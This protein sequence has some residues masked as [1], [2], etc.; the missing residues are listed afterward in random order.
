MLC[1]MRDAECVN[2]RG[3]SVR[4]GEPVVGREGDAPRV[5]GKLQLQGNLKELPHGARA[6]NPG[7][8]SAD[9]ARRLSGLRVRHLERDPHI[10]QDV[11][12][13][14]V[15][16]AVAIDDQCGSVLGELAAESV[17][18]RNGQ[19]NRLDNARAAALAQLRGYAGY[20]GSRHSFSHI[21]GKF[22][23]KL[24]H[25][26]R[27]P[28]N[29]KNVK[30]ENRDYFAW[31]FSDAGARCSPVKNIH[32]SLATQMGPTNKYTGPWKNAG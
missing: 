5:A 20:A 18:T 29:R 2:S 12:L 23:G 22:P 13:R 3:R 14:L 21:F 11:V 10:F 31:V 4:K 17:D 15:A 24:V 1:Q 26:C 7:N 19:G 32:A 28:I 16:A 30:K 8:A 9:G 25:E 6:L 27:P